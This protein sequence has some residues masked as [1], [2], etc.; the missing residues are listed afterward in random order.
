MA[1]RYQDAA[2]LKAMFSNPDFTTPIEGEK[3]TGVSCAEPHAV[4]QLVA[5]GVALKDIQLEIAADE[6]GKKVECHFCGR[7]IHHD[8]KIDEAAVR[9]YIKNPHDVPQWYWS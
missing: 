9:D 3:R 5:K 7:W 8:G 2:E 4:S 1:Q 6:R